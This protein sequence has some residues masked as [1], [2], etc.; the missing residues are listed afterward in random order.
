MTLPPACP[1]RSCSSAKPAPRKDRQD[2]SGNGTTAHCI[3]L[4][5]VQVSFTL[6]TSFEVPVRTIKA[7][8]YEVIEKGWGEFDI[9]VK[10]RPLPQCA[11][12]KPCVLSC[13]MQA[14]LQLE[15][16]F[17]Q[18]RCARVHQGNGKKYCSRFPVCP[19]AYSEECWSRTAL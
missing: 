16:L 7:M 18:S 10:A 19:Y 13:V 5:L 2:A 12:A 14:F 6:H 17:L 3:T 15:L 11:H 9:L 1:A 4:T 8:P